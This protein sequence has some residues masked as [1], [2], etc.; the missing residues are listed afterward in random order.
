[1]FTKCY[2]SNL[3][4]LYNS[5]RLKHP[6]VFKSWIIS[7]LTDKLLT[8][9]ANLGLENSANLIECHSEPYVCL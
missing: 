9:A 8:K 7:S 5:F 3:P 4:S 6:N 2:V 1:M